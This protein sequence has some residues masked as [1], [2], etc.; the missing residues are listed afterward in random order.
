MDIGKDLSLDVFKLIQADY[1]PLV[2]IHLQ[3][4]EL[5]EVF[6][7]HII[8]PVGTVTHDQMGSVMCQSPSLLVLVIYFLDPLEALLFIHKTDLRLIGQLVYLPI[9][10]PFLNVPLQKVLNMVPPSPAMF[11][12]VLLLGSVGYL[13]LELA[14]ALSTRKDK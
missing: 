4:P 3:L 1:R 14:K 9:D 11:A 8:N 2:I 13:Y 5:G 7:V 6:R 10:V 12:L